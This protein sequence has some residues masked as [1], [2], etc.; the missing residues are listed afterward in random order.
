MCL[1]RFLVVAFFN[2]NTDGINTEANNSA[3]APRIESRGESGFRVDTQRQALVGSIPSNSFARLKINANENADTLRAMVNSVTT[4]RLKQMNMRASEL[5]YRQHVLIFAPAK[6]KIHQEFL[7]KAHLN[8]TAGYLYRGR[9]KCALA[10]SRC[11]TP[12]IH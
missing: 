6:M 11:I 9:V 4:S 5:V 12:S 7:N 3:D 2:G 10:F 1:S 8:Q